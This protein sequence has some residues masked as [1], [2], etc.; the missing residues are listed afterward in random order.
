M[1]KLFPQ[2]VVFLLVLTKLVDL[3]FVFVVNNEHKRQIKDR[4]SDG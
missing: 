2:N 4:Q 1:C 3:F